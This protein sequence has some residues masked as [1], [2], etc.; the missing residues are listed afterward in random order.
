M[1]VCTFSFQLEPLKGTLAALA[2]AEIIGWVGT[3]KTG[4]A[5]LDS[6]LIGGWVLDFKY[7]F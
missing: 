5:Y 7:I 3:E 6:D 1:T 2:Q 4:W